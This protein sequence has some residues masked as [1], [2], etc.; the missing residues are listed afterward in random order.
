MIYIESA[1]LSA[2]F[3]LA[4]EYYLATEKII[5]DT[6]VFL[7]RTAPT[8]VI[9]KFQNAL[10]ELDRQ[11][12]EDKG[13]CIARRMS[14]GGTIYN[15]EGGLMFTYIVPE[16]KPEIDFLSFITPVIEALRKMGVNASA[17]G[18]NDILVDGKKVSGNAQFKTGG[19][20]VHHG[21]LMFDVDIGEVVRATTPKPYKITSKSIQSVRERVTNIREHLPAGADMTRDEFK[22][23]LALELAGDC[24]H[25]VLSDADLARVAEIAEERFSHNVWQAQPRFSL[26]KTLHFA[27][28]T[29]EFSLETRQN[30]ILS[31]HLTGDFFGSVDAEEICSLLVDTELEENALL[32]AIRPLSGRL[33]GITPEEIA[34]GLCV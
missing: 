3:N 10:E 19:V 20:T 30:K 17:S 15:D 33:L 6:V 9:G 1:S 25:L 7:W 26:E 14:G 4:L 5:N 16:N 23:R 21:T 29:M 12:T 2:H 8:V 18:R 22:N 24:P 11:Y 28:G 27:G 31:A 13:I 34:H 32:S